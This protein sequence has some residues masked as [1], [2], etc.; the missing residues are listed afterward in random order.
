MMPLGPPFSVPVAATTLPQPQRL[1]G[2]DALAAELGLDAA[3]WPRAEMTER[4]AGNQP[5]PGQ[6]AQ[7]S[8]YAGHQFG[9]YTRQLGDGRALL[10]ARLDTPAGPAELQL[11]GAGPTPFAR[12]LDGRAVLRSS[13]REYLAS[14]AMHALGVPTTRALALIGSTLLVQRE[15]AETA[16]V[17]CR[18]APSFLR[19][20]HFEYWARAGDVTGNMAGGAPHPLGVL[21]DHVITQHFAH[22][23]D[24]ADVHERRA[25][26]LTEVIERQARLMAMWQTLGFC[27]G[28]LNTDNCSILGLTLDYG[29]YGF[30]ER[31]R[32]H[33]VCNH[34]DTEGRYRYEA[35]PAIGAWNCA[36]LLDACVGLLDPRPDAATERAQAIQPAYQHAYSATVLTRWRAKLGLQEAHAGDADLV[37]QLLTLMQRSRCDFTLTW[38][39]LADSTP[40]ELRCRFAEPAAFDAWHLTWQQRLAAEGVAEPIWRARLRAANPKVVLRNHLAQQAIDAAEQG[41]LGEL[42]TLLRALQRPFDADAAEARFARPAPPEQAPLEVSCSS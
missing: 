3:A 27:H 18:V 34:S 2:N 6:A 20:G 32:S 23:A 4:L 14:E 7:A 9:S 29:P 31:F 21:A 42:Q 10:I 37:L 1:L 8:V 38:R 40:A 24:I 16:A 25:A 13:I 26:W 33:H 17:L 5:W 35:Q 22:L 30:M 11:K 41:E 12:G 36:R 19:F 15:R 28:V 39:A